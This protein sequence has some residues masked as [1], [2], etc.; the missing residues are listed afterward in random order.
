[1]RRK[2]RVDEENQPSSIVPKRGRGYR[3]S[4]S[5][6]WGVQV[7]NLCKLIAEIDQKRNGSGEADIAAISLY[8]Q[9]SKRLSGSRVVTEICYFFQ[10]PLIRDTP[11]IARF[12]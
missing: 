9:L 6:G 11:I 4:L 12:R 5:S 7:R 1:M 10:P 8:C 2:E 3:M